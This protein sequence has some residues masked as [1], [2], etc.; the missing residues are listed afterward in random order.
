MFQPVDYLI[1]ETPCVRPLMWWAHQWDVNH[2]FEIAHLLRSYAQRSIANEPRPNAGRACA[3]A[4]AQ[5]RLLARTRDDRRRELQEIR[6]SLRSA[7][8]HAKTNNTP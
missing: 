4:E 3:V 7:F 5:L 8:R 2:E 6:D 1:D